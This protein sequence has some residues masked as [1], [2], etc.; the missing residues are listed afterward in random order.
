ML[1]TKLVVFFAVI[2]VCGR[3]YADTPLTAKLTL[4][5]AK[6]LPGLPTAFLVSIANAS[7]QPQQVY[8]AGTLSVTAVDTAFDAEVN[9][10]TALNLPHE[11]MEK[12]NASYCLHIP[13]VGTKELYIDFSPSLAG[14][15]YFLDPRLNVSGT[16]GLK[17]TLRATAS[18]GSETDLPT[19]TATFTIEQPEGVDA[20]AWAWLTQQVDTRFNAIEWALRGNAL[21]AQLRARFPNSRYTM[22]TS[23]LGAA[24]KEELLTNIDAALGRTLQR[25][26]ATL[27]YLRRDHSW[28]NGIMSRLTHCATCR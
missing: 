6:V 2:T 9:G 4:A 21:A 18:D 26:Y 12:C 11:Q 5:P 15:A 8:D 27:C 20:D 19:Q 28:R 24:T 17:L 10:R 16:Y 25:D 23:A 14:N 13:P 22:W 7:N 1:K 3:I